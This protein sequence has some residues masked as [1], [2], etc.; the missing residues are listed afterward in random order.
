[1]SL[2]IANL[3]FNDASMLAS[4]KVGILAVSL[5]AGVGGFLILKSTRTASS[6]SDGGPRLP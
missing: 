2:F 5:V 3:A 4:A 6:G 1:M